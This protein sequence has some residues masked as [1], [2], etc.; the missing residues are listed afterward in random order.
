MK[1]EK[2]A[3]NSN[4]ELLRI[5]SMYMIVF[6]H[7]GVY[8]DYFCT[9]MAGKFFSGAVNGICNIGVTCFILISGYYGARFGIKKFVRMECMMITYSLLETVVLRYAMPETMEGAALLEQVI[10]SL[11]PFIT[12]KYWFYSSYVCL[13]LLSGYIQKFIDMMEREELSRFL[14]LLLFLFSVLPTC[15]YFELVPDSG[16][17]L[18]QMVMIYIIGR[19]IRL[20]QD[21]S[22]PK[23][24]GLVFCG[25]WVVNGISHE[26]PFQL[27][28]VSHHLCKDNSMTNIIMAIILFYLFKEMK[29]KSKIVNKAAGHIFAVFALNYSLVSV[30]MER[31][32]KA[33]WKS[34]DGILGFLAMALAVFLIMALCLMI[35]VIREWIFGR[36]DRKLGD[37]VFA[38]AGAAEIFIKKRIV[39]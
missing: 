28:G 37:A 8:L 11:L 9:G 38:A 20:F 35:G 32:M 39:D 5:L 33:G 3:R 15:F 6:V 30:I 31:M 10:K 25:L 14:L 22:M 17:G 2:P 13:L 23:W 12:R 36:A 16:K 21:I 26:I 29:L 34:P 18:V 19:Y 24:A 1:S 4:H 7:S 27:G